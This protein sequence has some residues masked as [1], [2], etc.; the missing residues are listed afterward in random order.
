MICLQRQPCALYPE[1]YQL[2]IFTKTRN[3]FTDAND[4]SIDQIQCFETPFCFSEI[5]D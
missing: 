5:Q 1:N 4:S 3:R 2:C